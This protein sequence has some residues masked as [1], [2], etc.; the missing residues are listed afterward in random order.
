MNELITRWKQELPD[1]FKKV[2]NISLSIGGSAIA[3][4]TLNATI[5]LNLN[6]TLITICSYVVAFC[7]AVAGTSQLTKQ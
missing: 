6:T 5:P 4:I 7:G 2:R 3:V 1:F